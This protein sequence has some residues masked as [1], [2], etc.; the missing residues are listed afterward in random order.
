MAERIRR[1]QLKFGARRGRL[2]FLLLFLLVGFHGIPAWGQSPHEAKLIEAAKRERS[3]VWY[4]AM[5]IDAAR[6]LAEA[7]EKKY[8]F[9]KVNY[10]RVGTAQMINRIV[11]ETLAGK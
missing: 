1:T 9:I 11:T 10:I 4:T 8:G 7:F 5:S 3:M 2:I 6:P